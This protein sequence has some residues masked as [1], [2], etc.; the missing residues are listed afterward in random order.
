MSSFEHSL[1]VFAQLLST[2]TM[3]SDVLILGDLA[4]TKKTPARDSE[5]A[6]LFC[7]VFFFFYSCKMSVIIS[8]RPAV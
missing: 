7:P 3:A 1:T 4:V 6:T 8:A 2:K 5:R